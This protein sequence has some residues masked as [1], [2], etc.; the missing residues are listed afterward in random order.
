MET[1]ATNKKYHDNVSLMFY[2]LDPRWASHK[3]FDRMIEKGYVNALRLTMDAYG[4]TSYGCKKAKENGMPVWLVPPIYLPKQQTIEQYMEKIDAFVEKLKN[5]DLWDTIIGFQWDE[6]LLRKGHTNEAL[7]E[8][9]KAMSE[10][11]GKR[12]FTNFSLYEIA[13]KR[14]NEG[15]PDF[16]WLLRKDCSKYLTDVG[17]DLYGWDLRPEYQDKL[18]EALEKRGKQEGV[19]LKTGED[20][21]QHY[22][23]VML[24]LVENNEKV[25]IW[26]YPCA[27]NCKPAGGIPADEGY[28]AGHLEGFKNLLLKQKNPGGI[29]VYTYKLSLETHLHHKNPDRWE[30]YEEVCRQVCK[31][32]TETKH[33]N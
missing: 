25:R 24:K 30:K 2:H 5:E 7:L 32:L 14:G 29:C 9:T 11:Y 13:G 28:C 10:A 16:Q 3:D 33:N 22:T 6:P 17:F 23:D 20:L 31:E 27:Y 15:D 19:V 12:I 21:Y 8:M 18:Q 1:T 4:T 26:Y